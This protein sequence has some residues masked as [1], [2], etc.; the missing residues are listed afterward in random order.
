MADQMEYFRDQMFRHSQQHA[1]VNQEQMLTPESIKQAEAN[2]I[3]TER[4]K[5]ILKEAIDGKHV[6]END[7]LLKSLVHYF[8][9]TAKTT[10]G[11]EDALRMAIFTTMRINKD[12]T[13]EKRK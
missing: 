4:L 7:P 11:K 2:E 9:S 5:Q 8:L 13:V 10:R 3:Y 6:E 12:F 1:G